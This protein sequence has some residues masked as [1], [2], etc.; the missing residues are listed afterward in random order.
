MATI[1][2]S[3]KFTMPVE[4]VRE[5]IDKLGESLQKEQGMQYHWENNTKAV[6]QH[7]AAKGFVCINIDCVDLE[8]K[9]GLLYS[10]MAPLLKSKIQEMADAYIK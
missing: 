3:K 10:A 1:K 7:K 9:M 6:F 4:Q 2:I 5:G 8:L